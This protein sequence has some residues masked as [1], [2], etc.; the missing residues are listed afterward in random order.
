MAKKE[1]RMIVAAADV[2]GIVDHGADVDTQLK[3]LSFEDKGIKAKLAECVTGEF[4]TGESSVRLTG[5]KAAAVITATEKTDIDCSAESFAA[6]RK[7]IDDGILEGVVERKLSLVVPP[8]DVQRAADALKAAGIMATVTES[9][10]V[11]AE[12]LRTQEASS[13]EQSKAIGAL[14]GCVTTDVSYRVKYERK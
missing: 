12:T 7:A 4:Q 14:K 8:A 10:S 11:S 9:L 1:I 5:E 6:V 2:A 3:N 13:V